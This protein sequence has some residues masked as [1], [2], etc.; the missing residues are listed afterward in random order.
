MSD[1]VAIYGGI[2]LGR[3]RDYTAVVLLGLMDGIY[4]V[5]G[6][7]AFK[8]P[9]QNQMRS[10]KSI[11]LSSEVFSLLR[12]VCIDR[13]GIGSMPSETIDGFIQDNAYGPA[14]P[15]VVGVAFNEKWKVEA[16]DM[17]TRMLTQGILKHSKDKSQTI[18]SAQVKTQNFEQKGD[19]RKYSHP[20]GSH[21]DLL[22]ALSLACW[23]ARTS[24]VS[25]KQGAWV[26]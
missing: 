8:G 24:P 17:L 26:R 12:V 14:V 19:R 4:Y 2:D 16:I 23:G 3:L 9:W 13:T 22:W 21:D 11:L 25:G 5:L 20:S 18:L 1:L 15:Y 6:A 10:I 7:L